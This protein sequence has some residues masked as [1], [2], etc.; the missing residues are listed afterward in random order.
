MSRS[1]PP[2]AGLVCALVVAGLAAATVAPA[3]TVTIIRDD[4]GVPH[5]FGPNLRATWFGVGYASA[6]DRLWQAD[7]LRRLGTGTSAE[8][9]GPSALQGDIL[10]RAVLGPP[11]RRAALFQAASPRT[12]RIIRAYVDGINA[13]IEEAKATGQLPVEYAGLGLDPPRPWT[14]DD[15]I[16]T[17]MALLQN[18]GEGGADEFDF[19]IDLQRLV[20]RL[21]PTAGGE[22]FFD[23][24]WLNDPGAVPTVPA[25]GTAA[26]PMSQ[27]TSAEVLAGVLELDVQA[28]AARYRRKVRGWQRNARR[29]GLGQPPASNAIAIG[30]Q[31]SADGRPLLLHGP[32][33]GYTV[34]QINHEIGI[35][36]GGFNVTGM[37]IAGIPGIP[38]G[39]AKN[40]AWTWTT[41][42]TD[43]NDL[44]VETVNPAN[45][46]QYL[47]RGTFR[48]FDCRGELIPIR[49]S[50]PSQQI[51]C[52]SVHG[53]L[54]EPA[55]G[56]TLKSAV[57]G[58]ELDSMTAVHSMMA[59]RGIRQFQR[60]VSQAAYNFNVLYADVRGNI[61]Y[62]HAGRIPIRAPGDNPWFLHVGT[63]GAEWQ[64]F[65]PFDQMPHARN[66]AQGWLTNWN[67]K[68][69]ANWFNS[70]RGFAQWGPVARVQTLVNLLEGLPP[71]SATVGTI[72]QFNLLGGWTTDTPSGNASTVVVSTLLGDL[73]ARVDAGAD[74]RL[75]AIVAL[76]G[77]W[78]L[79]QLDLDVDG[80]YDNPAVAIFNTWWQ[81]F[82][83]S[84]FADELGSTLERN[85][86]ANMAGRLLRPGSGLPLRHDYLDGRTLTQA[87]TNALIAAAD[88]LTADFGSADPAD[89]LARAA[90]IDWQQIGAVD[91][92]D[93]P[94]MN[95]GTYN[96][97]SHLGPGAER[98]ALNVIAP[99]Q[100]GSPL[101]PHFADQLVNYA[102]WTYKTMRLTRQS[103]TGQTESTLELEV[104]TRQRAGRGK[105]R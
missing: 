102:T 98:F 55:F 85:V 59:A 77:G 90:V 84:V 89:W 21:G 72:Q 82:V 13:W 70:T 40:H 41:G 86:V 45:P 36:G 12:K 88:Q 96:Q 8:I 62:W 7:L 69:R 51:F 10:A 35:H 67:N 17:A 78:D 25:S 64:G 48:D 87:V 44:Y 11:E 54:V 37:T 1:H 42:T 5:V 99:G 97:I 20:A 34:P 94:W 26:V 93:T 9:F 53:P 29:A 105:R 68:P 15:S 32:Q 63:G 101:S 56:V 58:L 75:P 83:T 39:I 92:P 61:A 95:R 2:R 79:L 3:A 31:L 74:P 6:Q 16:A 27:E 57:R 28:A 76:L 50:S 66:P 100:S 81:A 22:V 103:L 38:I 19:V 73:L 52:D 4:F 14:I 18:F 47:F 43:N 65:I 80:R 24:H 60:A 71:G 23:S 49:G 104:P 46:G 30:P 33:M 91:V